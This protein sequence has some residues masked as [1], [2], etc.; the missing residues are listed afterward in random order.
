MTLGRYSAD[1]WKGYLL[2]GVDTEKL[3]NYVSVICHLYDRQASLRES[4]GVIH[5]VKDG[6]DGRLGLS[7]GPIAGRVSARQVDDAAREAQRSSIQ[8]VHILGWAFE[9][10]IG[11]VKSELERTLGVKLE[12]IMIRPD[13]LAEGLGV[14]RPQA[15]FSPLALP[16]AAIV[17]TRAGFSVQLKGVAVYDRKTHITEYKAADKGYVAAW[18]LDEDYD[19]DCFVDCQMFFDF[20]QKPAIERSLGIEVDPDEWTLRLASDPFELG[21]YGRVAV[22]V[23]DVYGNESTVVKDLRDRHG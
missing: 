14:T 8:E 21:K 3:E 18:Y 16:D 9:A 15:L 20:R 4:L 11:E 5:A 13:T 12:L 17:S 7:I 23:V 1:D 10:N 6:P 22:R 19:G 2:G